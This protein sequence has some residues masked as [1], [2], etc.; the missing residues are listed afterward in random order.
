MNFQRLKVSVRGVVQGVG[1]RPFIYRLATE[2]GLNGWVLNS[3]QGVFIEV[4]GVGDTLREFLLRIEKEKPVRASIQS[5]ESCLL[6]AVGYDR[7]E[8]TSQRADR[9]ENRSCAAGHC[10][11]H[12]LFARDYGTEGPALPISVHKLH[13]LRT[14]IY[15]RG[16]VAV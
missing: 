12:R 16:G 15:D 14:A 13:Q 10:H 11:L 1:F 7:F 9:A 3:A 8:I 5:L 4:E 2:L 6:D